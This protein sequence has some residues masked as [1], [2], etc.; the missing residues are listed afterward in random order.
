MSH[1]SEK[2]F[3]KIQK[4]ARLQIDESEQQA[5]VELLEKEIDGVKNIFNIDTNN[6]EGLTNPYEM[7][8]ESYTDEISDGNKVDLIMKT[9][10][11]EM[12]DYFAVP[13]V[14]D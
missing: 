12:Y 1:L 13:K 2:Q 10:P 6:L 3:N 4:L 8:L 7:Y 14:I 11:K 9:A 5:F